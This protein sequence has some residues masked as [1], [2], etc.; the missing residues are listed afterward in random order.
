MTTKQLLLEQFSS[1]FNQPDWFVSL[2]TALNGLNAEQAAEHDGRSNN[3]I[4]QIVNHLIYWNTR[5]LNRFMGIPNPEAK[6]NNDATF[7]GERISGTEEQWNETI[8]KI[9][10]VMS[11]WEKSLKKADE[12]KLE[13]KPIKDSEGSWYSYIGLINTHN[14]YHIGQIVTIRKQQHSWDSKKGVN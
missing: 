8:K 3:S 13:L 2:T 7:E 10:E 6:D 11:E 9:N 1:C 4:W 12:S 14:A 5:Y